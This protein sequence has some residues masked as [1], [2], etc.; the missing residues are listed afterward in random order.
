[1]AYDFS[2]IDDKEFEVFVNDL[3]EKVYNTKVDRFKSWKDK[4][5]DW[6]FFYD[7]EKTAIIQTKQYLKTWYDGLIRKLKES[8]IEKVKKLS[9]NWELD[10]YIFATDLPLSNENKKEIKDIFSPYI[11]STDDIFWNE[12]LNS[13]L[14]KNND[15]ERK[16]YRLW[17]TS[18]NVLQNILNNAIIWRSEFQ[19]EQII[20]KSKFFIE[21]SSFNEALTRLEDDNVII[22]TWEPWIWKT[23]L[24]ENLCLKLVAL[25]DYK[26]YE[27]QD[28]VFEAENIWNKEEKQLFYFDDFLWSNYFEAINNNQDSHIINFINRVKKDTTWKKKF[29]LNSRSNILNYWLNFSTIFWNSKIQNNE[30][31]LEIKSLSDYEKAQ[32]LYKHIYYSDLDNEYIN[33]IYKD[34]NYFKIIK[35][36]N[37]NP[38]LIEFITS[39]DRVNVNSNKYFNFLIHKLDNPQ[40]IWRDIFYNQSNDYIR[41]LIKLVVFNGWY[42]LEKDL[43]YS[44]NKIKDSIISATHKSK[45]FN[46]VI[47]VAVRS[48]LNRNINSKNWEVSYTL[49]NPSI[50]DFV[51]SEYINDQNELI[52]IYKNLGTYASIKN[53]Y[54]I[55]KAW[56]DKLEKKLYVEKWI[57]H[58]ILNSIIDNFDDNID[59]DY[60]YYILKLSSEENIQEEKIIYELQK[61]INNTEEEN[62]FQ[63]TFVDIIELIDKYIDKLNIDSYIFLEKHI[64]WK[65]LELDLDDINIIGLFL[66]KL[67]TKFNILNNEDLLY[68]FKENIEYYLIERIKE[69]YHEIDLENFITKN[70]YED[71]EV[72]FDYDESDII[73]EIE[74]KIDDYISDFSFTCINKKDFDTYEITSSSWI[75][76]EWFINDYIKDNW[77]YDKEKFSSNKNNINS[78]YINNDIEIDNLFHR[79]V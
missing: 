49:F 63:N 77:N 44:Y 56:L 13:E 66:D 72:E 79:D 48:F 65:E 54:S 78:V 31:M 29:I 15:I 10:K 5:I 69:E 9:L 23:T 74:F 12:N 58:A 70:Y 38:R 53:L 7:N 22:I 50:S 24:S 46:F 34:K 21:I 61:F 14:S 73:H 47:K 20:E 27:I 30:F 55:Y 36:K 18:T 6:K 40:D 60:L 4:W 45:D 76:I 17:I 75:N 42:I 37:F 68:H 71:W 2:Q 59:L 25:H 33:E 43:L 35:H 16:Y 3:L 19:F 64:V 26:F 62:I 41:L 11:K 52:K 32:I 57:Y 28:W 8:E 51:I 1:M 67:F 39:K